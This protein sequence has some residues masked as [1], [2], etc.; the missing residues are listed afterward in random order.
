MKTGEVIETSRVTLE[1][2]AT[3]PE[4]A[5][6]EH[7][8]QILASATFQSSKRCRQFLDYVCT[9]RLLG[10]AD[11]LKERTIAIEVFGR[12][13]QS[14]LGEDTIVRVSA[15]ELR[16]RL[17][18]YY[19]TPEGL[20]TDLRVE[21]PTGSYTPRFH[22][23]AGT[24]SEAVLHTPSAAPE[25]TVPTS[26]RRW[27]LIPAAIV[28]LL[29]IFGL[30]TIVKARFAAASQVQFTRF[31]Q[32]VFNS[33]DPLLIAVAHPLVYHPSYRALRLNEEAVGPTAP[34]YGQRPLQIDAS[35]LNGND[36]VPVTN[37]Y[38]GFGDMVAATQV[39]AMLARHSRDVRLHLANSVPFEDLRRSGAL[40]IG[41]TS[42]HW[43]MEL[44]QSWRFQFVRTPEPRTQIMDMGDPTKSPESRRHWGI[45]AQ[46]DGSASEDFM[47]IS[48][49]INSETGGIL[50]NA[51]GLKQFGT[52]A[53][54]QLIADPDQ[55]EAVLR[56]LPAGWESKNLQ[57]VLHAKVIGNA[58]AQPEVV[59]WHVW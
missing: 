52:E 38:V 53:A 21:L 23:T 5:I 32:P 49:I 29:A 11:A 20:A 55:F 1:A 25:D 35:K 41:G 15:R 46:A 56:R 7:V 22:Y 9:R 58:P 39:S 59:A 37:Q 31:W 34:P 24:V 12:R 57:V 40:L 14:D 2:T 18:Q 30:V 16:K 10:D 27:I 13:P 6:R 48:R 47:L 4:A 44:Q 28:V 45:Q 3:P 51:A 54:G 36:M 33:S 42:N 43:V 26:S 8:E 50:L 17:V 19:A